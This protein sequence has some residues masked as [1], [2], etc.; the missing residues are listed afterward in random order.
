MAKKTEKNNRL[1]IITGCNGFAGKYLVSFLRK[2][3]KAYRVIGIDLQRSAAC[4]VDLYVKN[5]LSDSFPPVVRGEMERARK[6][7]CFHLAGLIFE[8]NIKKLCL[9]NISA[10]ANTFSSLVP[11]KDKA[12]AVNI[13]SAAEYGYHGTKAITEKFQA[14]PVS[15]YGFSKLSQ[16]Q[17]AYCFFELYNLPVIMSR[18]FNIVG[19]GQT[20]KLV[21]GRLVSEIAYCK[22]QKSGAVS[23]KNTGTY[24]DFVDVRDAVKAY[25]LL[26]EKGS[27]GEL[28]NIASGRSVKIKYVADFILR[29]AR[30]K[31]NIDGCEDG[32][33]KQDIPYQKASIKKIQRE[34][35]WKPGYSLERS[36]RD[37][38][39][40]EM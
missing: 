3:R 39:A 13:G 11:Y 2:R 19:P 10:T 29:I 37:M 14:N 18:T 35:G 15:A 25:V 4:D 30:I 22:K 40:F 24:R 28:Y 6:I 33:G 32:P 21:C 23:L 31:P 20:D 8:K 38:L 34:T 27:P 36:L 17:L 26:A 1:V 12:V 7:L 5:D 9:N 16:T